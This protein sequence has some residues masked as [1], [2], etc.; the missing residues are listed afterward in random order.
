MTE[1]IET[2]GKRPDGLKD[3]S[4][5]YVTT[6]AFNPCR[7]FDEYIVVLLR[8]AEVDGILSWNTVIAYALCEFDIPEPYKITFKITENQLAEYECRDG[9]TAICYGVHTDTYRDYPY[10][11]LYHDGDF[12]SVTI[13]GRTNTTTE[14]PTDLV[15]KIRDL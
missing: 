5:V 6:C 7:S 9:S 4:F 12:N 8:T 3:D 14:M 10:R 1:W 15:R 11:V 2:D 13:N